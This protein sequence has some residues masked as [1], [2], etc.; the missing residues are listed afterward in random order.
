MDHAGGFVFEDMESRLELRVHN[1]HVLGP[2]LA[3]GLK[4]FLIHLG[5]KQPVSYAEHA[6]FVVFLIS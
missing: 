2:L 4:I 1:A 5:K 3:L 6:D